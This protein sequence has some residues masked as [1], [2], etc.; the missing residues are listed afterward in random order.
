MPPPTLIELLLYSLHSKLL[1]Y[2]YAKWDS[3]GVL[4]SWAWFLPQI[5]KVSFAA[6][7]VRL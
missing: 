5:L 6:L 4:L 2:T 7:T 3:N 1:K